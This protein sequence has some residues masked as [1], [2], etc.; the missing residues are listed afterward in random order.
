MLRL[1]TLLI[2]VC[3]VFER[4]PAPYL[5]TGTGRCKRSHIHTPV[6]PHIIDRISGKLLDHNNART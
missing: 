6:C 4:W 1:S 3:I 2:S 5:S